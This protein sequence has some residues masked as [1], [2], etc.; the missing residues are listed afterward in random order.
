MRNSVAMSQSKETEELSGD[1]AL[2]YG[3]KSPVYEIKSSKEEED[4]FDFVNQYIKVL[5]LNEVETQ[6]L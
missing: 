4:E 2:D 3:T 1:P 5:R 6:K